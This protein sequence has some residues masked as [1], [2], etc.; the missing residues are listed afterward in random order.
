MRGRRGILTLVAAFAAACG[1]GGEGD[2]D[3]SGD[4]GVDARVGP[5]AME[6]FDPTVVRRFE[7]TMT[8]N[9]WDALNI[10][11][12]SEV[13]VPADLRYGDF[14]LANIAVRYKGAVGS[15]ALCF[16]QQGNRICPKLSMKL[17]FDEY[18]DRQRFAGLKRI[19][20][21]AMYRDPSHMK[22]RI[23]YGLFRAAGVPAPRSAHARLVV[24]GMDLGLFAL[25]EEIDGE[26]VEDH[27]RELDGTGEGNLYKE[28]WPVHTTEAPYRMAL[29]TNEEEN[30]PVDKMV[31]FATALNGADAS[32]FRAV[33]SQWMD[34]PT[35]VSY[36]AVDRLIDH[37]DG[38]VAWY[39]PGGGA[40]CF[41]HNYYWYEQANADRVWLLP[42]DLDNTMM[43]PSPIRDGYGMP[44]WNASPTDCALR[45]VFLGLY[46]RPP[47]C[48]KLIGLMAQVL[49]SDYQ[50]RT[51]EIL[52][53]PAAAAAL[54]AE[55]VAME[56]LLAPEV[57]TD[58]YGP[59][60][61][62]W[63]QAVA[64]L[65]ADLPALRARVAP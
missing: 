38:I 63:Q 47:A 20:F 2:D 54:E 1:G 15:L 37:W 27:F 3:G 49:W 55:I 57:A 64:D 31:R 59:G 30:P 34:L 6:L 17:K 21:H 18:V 58:M 35:L 51:S 53:G 5:T 19:N 16:D 61:A 24:N 36:L 29:D 25:V 33:V 41:N 12:R 11:P 32:T 28:V 45:Q 39:C 44:D 46:G 23:G 42:W 56:A 13:Y 62:A 48:D 43:V 52:A 10:D 7:L 4:G 50:A 14:E 22:E 40:Q 60:T 9:A 65:R 8:Q 26:F